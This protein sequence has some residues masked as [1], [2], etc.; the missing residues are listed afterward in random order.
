M[1]RIPYTLLTIAAVV[2]STSCAPKNDAAPRDDSAVSASTAS[3]STR[4]RTV[5]FVGTSLTAG[6][7]LDPDSAYPQLIA[8]KIRAANLPFEVVNAGVS[9]ET[10]SGLLRRLDWLMRGRFDVIVIETGA[11]DGLRGIPIETVRQNVDSILTRVRRVHPQARLLLVQMEALPNF[12]PQYTTGFRSFYRELA[13]KHRVSLAPFLLDG[14]AGRAEL[15][16][17]DGIH[18]NME[19]ERIVADN[20]WRAVEPVLRSLSP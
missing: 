6:L 4:S 2:L 1:T 7:G 12:G 16:Q 17:R 3:E 10:T 11:N 8:E 5:L 20:V 15:N 18:P 19:G 9:G 14:V 13:E